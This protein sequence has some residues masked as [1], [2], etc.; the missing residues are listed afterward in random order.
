M[1][2]L[3]RETKVVV[4]TGAGISAESGI[5]TFRDSGGLWENHRI[6]DIATW[7]GFIKNPARVW[8]FYRERWQQS[9]SVQPNPAHLAL[10]EL[11]TYLKDNFTLITQNVDGLHTKA[12]SRNT[13]AMHGSLDMSL[14]P[15]CKGRYPME[16]LDNTQ[17]VPQCAKCGAK[18]RPDIVWFGE[19]PYYLFEIENKLKCCDIFIIVGTSG[20]VYPAAG[21]VM[22]AK[23]MGAFTVAINLDVPDNMSF[24]DEFHEGRSG[25]ILPQLVSNWIGK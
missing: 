2:R 15:E 3:T 11:E 21:F 24:I 20:V 19:I 1:K 8:Q 13:M 14:C 7:N 4:L 18:L 25:V 22:T 12:G 6:E 16:D 17:A 10:L 23:L 5:K 9:R